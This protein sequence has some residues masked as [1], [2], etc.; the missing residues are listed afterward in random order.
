MPLK[1][2]CVVVW[3]MIRTGFTGAID[4]EE[5][6]SYERDQNPYG[7]SRQR[8]GERDL[9]DGYYVRDNVFFSI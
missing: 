9:L 1:F 8:I 5:Q 6:A 7:D 4:T 3:V 2:W